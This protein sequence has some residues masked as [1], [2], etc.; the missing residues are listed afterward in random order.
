MYDVG[1]WMADVRCKMLDVG[2]CWLRSNV[3]LVAFCK[4]CIDMH[5]KYARKRLVQFHFCY[6]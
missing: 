4:I 1:S 6:F 3:V 5:L 2:G